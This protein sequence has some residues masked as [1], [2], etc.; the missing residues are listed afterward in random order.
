M[1]PQETHLSYK[2]KHRLKMKGWK[3]IVQANVTQRKAGVY[4]LILDKID[5]KI[6]TITIDKGGRFMLIKGNTHQEDIALI[7]IYSVNLGA[8]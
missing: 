5:F 3:M 8:P 4:I 1:L 2:D 6:K 7:Y